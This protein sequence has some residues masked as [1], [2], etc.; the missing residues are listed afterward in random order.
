M[1]RNKRRVNHKTNVRTII[2]THVSTISENLVKTG[3]ANSKIFG[4]TCQFLPS[5]PKVK[6]LHLII[7]GTTGLAVHQI[8]I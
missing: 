8:F 2:P 4:Q 1:G 5:T 7:S 6:I 3:P